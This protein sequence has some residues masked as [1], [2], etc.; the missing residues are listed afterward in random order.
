MAS[1]LSPL[2]VGAWD[3]SNRVVMAPM[4]RLRG[5][6]TGT[7]T[8]L[9][10]TYYAQ[11]ATSGLIITEATDSSPQ[12][13]GYAGAPGIWSAEQVAGWRIVTD[14]VHA[15]GGKI[16]VQLW[17]TG[18]ISHPS[19]QPNGALPVAPSAIAPKGNAVTWTGPQPFV[20]PRALRLDEIPGIVHQFEQAARN[21]RDA[22]FDGVEIHGANGYLI[23][24]F[25]RDGANHRTDAYG[26]T[27]ANRARLLFEILDRVVGVWGADRVALRLSPLGSN[28]SMSDSDPMALYRVVAEGLNRYGLAFLEIRVALPEGADM[29]RMIRE[30]FHGPLMLNESLTLDAANTL[31]E[32]GAIDLASFA[33]PFIGNPDLVERF[34]E[35]A[36][37]AESDKATW[38][39]GEAKGYIDYPSLTL[40]GKEPLESSRQV[41]GT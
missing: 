7:P 34:A 15:R 5:G 16:I 18:R 31:I 1:V 14:A 30:T 37:L 25:L 27:P 2:R 23:D 36:P 28:S 9:N 39:A 20:E 10:A 8:S 29:L 17:H 35:G 40:A 41:S 21:A 11:R 13:A 32:S 26:G 19:L 6:R 38:Y 3:L 4:T 12:A 24:Q 22:G 33:R